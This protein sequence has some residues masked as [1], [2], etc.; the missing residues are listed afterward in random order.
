MLTPFMTGD[1]DHRWYLDARVHVPDHV[2]YRWFEA[3]TLLLNLN[4]GQYHGLNPTG[5]RLLQLL[6]ETEGGV[7]EAVRRLATEYDVDEGQIANDMAEFC[8]QLAGRGLIEVDD[9]PRG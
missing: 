4:T 6:E 8:A 5:G 1:A 7:G 3:E 2:V 9:D